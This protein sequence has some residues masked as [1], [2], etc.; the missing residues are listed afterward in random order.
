LIRNYYCMKRANPQGIG[1][2][3]NP[4]ITFASIYG[5]DS[6]F[7]ARASPNAAHWLP[8][9]DIALDMLTGGLLTSLGD[10]PTLCAAS[11][12][13]DDCLGLMRDA[14]FRIPSDIYR[15]FDVK[16]YMRLI[17]K[18]CLGGRKIVTQHVHPEN[19]IPSECCWVSPSVLSFLNNKANLEKLVPVDIVPSRKILPVQEMI[20]ADRTWNP[21]CVIKAVTDESSGGGVD[22]YICHSPI[23]IQKAGAF[24]IECHH[25]VIEDYLNMR[26]NLCLNYCMSKEGDITYLGF[27]EQVSDVDGIYRGNWI[28][29]KEECPCEI[30]EA[31]M[32]VVRAAFDR[33][34]YG[35]FGM[36]VALLEDGHYKIFDLNFR[37]N[38]STP[39]VLYAESIRRKYQKHVM[40]FRRFT[41]EGNYRQMLDAV[42]KAMG[43][44]M[45]LPL[46]SC[47][48]SAGPYK[49][50][51]PLLIGLILGETRQDVLE[52]EKELASL[53]LNG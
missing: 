19:E 51:Q 53:G 5:N 50:Q 41:G 30:I 45:F 14:G 9:G 52:K 27:A 20:K 49:Q 1:I 44:E 37:A 36:D 3:V 33:G 4:A 31:G 38:G 26:R 7:V 28:D 21:P 35:F 13:T 12:S 47:D 17:K 29:F 11:V 23:D 2:E 10:M 48:P 8:K 25:V 15:Y 43:N 18:L 39:A 34:Y 16:D 32:K 24:F 46:G 40:R 42:Y 22:V 6:L